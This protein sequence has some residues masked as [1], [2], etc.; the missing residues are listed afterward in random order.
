MSQHWFPDAFPAELKSFFE[1]L[2]QD[3]DRCRLCGTAFIPNTFIGPAWYERVGVCLQCCR[4]LAA[5]R[6]YQH[7]GDFDGIYPSTL[8]K[9][10]TR[11]K[12]GRAMALRVIG[13]CGYKC[14]KCG[15][16]EN[17]EVDHIK[18]LA[19]GGEHVEENMQA[20]CGHCNRSK[21][22]KYVQG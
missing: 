22:A 21:G 4:N 15:T 3:T 9:L 18:P 13:R 14:M 20:L 6:A 17:L 1:R 7:S 12:I 11:P 5:L 2:Q 10:P 19:K 16:R 8:P